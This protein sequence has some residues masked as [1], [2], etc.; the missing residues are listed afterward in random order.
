LVYSL[1]L[2][3]HVEKIFEKI[4]KRDQEQE[5]A[6]KNK[7][8][9]ILDDPFRFKPLKRPMQGKWRVH[10]LKSFVLTYSIDEK[11]KKITIED[12]DHHDNVYK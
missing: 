3:E 9:Q 5:N 1:E 6:I 8:K 7:I 10:I 11:E 4:A 12:Y 2:R